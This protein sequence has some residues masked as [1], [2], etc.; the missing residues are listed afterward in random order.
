MDDRLC[1]K[2]ES[3]ESKESRVIKIDSDLYDQLSEIST[4]TGISIKTIASKM[5]N[6]AIER[7]DL[8]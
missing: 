2:I 7:T 8:V 5:L 4:K 6:Y 3:K 1:F